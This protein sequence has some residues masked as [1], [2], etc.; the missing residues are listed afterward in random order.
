MEDSFWS[1]HNK[2]FSE[3]EGASFASS[4]TTNMTGNT[5]LT[6]KIKR[7]M[8]KDKEV[9]RIS[10]ATP[11]V[12]E[13][14]LELFV[15]RLLAESVTFARAGNA[16]KIMPSHLKAAVHADTMMDFLKEIVQHAPDASV[17]A[18]EKERVRPAPDA[19]VEASMSKS[20]QKRKT[21]RTASSSKS[22]THE[23]KTR[24][25]PKVA[26]SS[27]DSSSADGKQTQISPPAKKRRISQGSPPIDMQACNISRAMQVQMQVQ[28]PE[29]AAALPRN[30]PLVDL[31]Q[32][33]HQY[34]RPEDDDYDLDEDDSC[35]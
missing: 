32:L 19:P 28:D 10:A 15:R 34:W 25:E 9:G 18:E 21:K 13:K 33:L 2:D 16:K 35:T 24:E 22:K 14:A 26:D 6:S 5:L 8:L 12:I 29:V 27:L 4:T 11:V 31:T 20:F 3:S 1:L 23:R 30:C 17:C 7:V